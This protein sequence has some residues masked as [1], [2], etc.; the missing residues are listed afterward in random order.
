MELKNEELIASAW[1]DWQVTKELGSGSYG[2]VYEVI[3]KD[4]SV[5]IC[6]AVKV[7]RIPC[8]KAEIET[9]QSEGMS[10]ENAHSFI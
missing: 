9:L 2:C 3:R 4:S 6:A 10:L 7:I 5:A 8:G 1:P